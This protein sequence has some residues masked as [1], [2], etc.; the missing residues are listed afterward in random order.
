MCPQSGGTRER[1]KTFC[2]QAIAQSR[3][4][5]GGSRHPLSAGHQGDGQGNAAGGRQAADPVRRGGGARRRYRAFCMVT[6]RGKTAMVEHFDVAFELEATLRERGKTKRSRC[7]TTPR[8]SPA[9]RHRAP[10]GAARAR[11]RDLVRPR[12][13]RRRPVRDPAPRR[14]HSLGQA[15]SAAARGSVS[16]DRR[17]HRRGD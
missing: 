13:H 4:A 8:W 16:R 5:G 6:G 11:T 7:C 2:D 10:A 15:L 17:Q 1:G 14:S 9:H 12:L 3:P